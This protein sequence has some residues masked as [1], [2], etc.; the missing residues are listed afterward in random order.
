MLLTSNLSALTARAPAS[1]TGLELHIFHRTKSAYF[2][3]DQKC[4]FFTLDQNCIFFTGPKVHIFYRT[5]SAYFSLDQN[6]I[7]LGTPRCRWHCGLGLWAAWPSSS[8]LLFVCFVYI[9]PAAYSSG[10]GRA[11]SSGPTTRCPRRGRRIISSSFFL[12][13]W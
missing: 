5:R 8:M 4:I 9:V 7:F 3:L 6:C 13:F 10:S 11:A 1:A 2:S 12:L